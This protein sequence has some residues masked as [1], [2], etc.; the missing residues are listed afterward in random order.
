MVSGGQWWSVVVSGGQWWSVV[1]R[2]GAH[3][4]W[5]QRHYF[6]RDHIWLEGVRARK[7]RDEWLS[8]SG[9]DYTY[10]SG[11]ELVIINCVEILPVNGIGE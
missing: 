11:R 6:Y 3:C 4:S 10:P 2:G 8:V 5:W 1:V 7:H 9:N